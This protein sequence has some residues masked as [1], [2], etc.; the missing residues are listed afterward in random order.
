M[1]HSFSNP[2]AGLV[3][4]GSGLD[5]FG[6]DRGEIFDVGSEVVQLE[7]AFAAVHGD[8]GAEDLVVDEGGEGMYQGVEIG[9]GDEQA[10]DAVAHQFG[11]A[12]DRGGD[13]RDAHGKGFHEHNRKALSEAGQAEDVGLRVEGSDA[14]LIDGAFEI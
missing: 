14:V 6:E 3:G 12:G 5:V 8:G 10:F 11:D 7:D 2:R 4:A 1:G 13:A 9:R